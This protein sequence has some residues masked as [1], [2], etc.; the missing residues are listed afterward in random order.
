VLAIGGAKF[1]R[2]SASRPAISKIKAAP[3]LSAAQA[4]TA[5]GSTTRA[6]T[7]RDAGKT[8]AGQLAA[9]H[10]ANQICA[11]KGKRID[12]EVHVPPVAGWDWNDALNEGWRP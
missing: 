11:R 12:I 4:K 1:S 10:L 2:C 6:A 5:F 3:V 7:V 9:F 8:F